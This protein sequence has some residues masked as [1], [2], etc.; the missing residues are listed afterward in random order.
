[1]L[2]VSFQGSDYENLISGPIDATEWVGPWND[3]FY[4]FYE[5][6]KYYYY[7]GMQ[8]R[9]HAAL[10]IKSPGG[11]VFLILINSSLKL[12]HILRMM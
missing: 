11:K 6:A 5:A 1:M 10:G 3:S 4:K 7:P 8:S 2:P 9:H 12:L